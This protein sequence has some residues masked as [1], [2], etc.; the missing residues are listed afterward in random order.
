MAG[1][2]ANTGAGIMANTGAGIMAGIMAN[3]GA[4]IMA[5]IMAKTG[6]GIMAAL[7]V[8]MAETVIILAPIMAGHRG[9]GT[10]AKTVTGTLR[11]MVETTRTTVDD[12]RGTRPQDLKRLQ[13]VIALP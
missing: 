2:M 11:T 6:A 4:G 13:V 7:A 3:T 8:T 10:M 5:G 1:I 9:R 12:G